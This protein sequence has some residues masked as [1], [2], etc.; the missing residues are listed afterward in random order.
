MELL[1]HPGTDPIPS[2][3]VVYAKEDNLALEEAHINPSTNVS[4]SRT[5]FICSTFTLHLSKS[6][7]TNVLTGKKGSMEG[8]PFHQG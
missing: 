4:R 8:K 7:S 1:Q 3:P 6:F 2:L 5:A